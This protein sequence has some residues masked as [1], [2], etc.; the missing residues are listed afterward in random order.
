MYVGILRDLKLAL[1]SSVKNPGMFADFPSSIDSIYDSLHKPNENYVVVV[2]EILHFC[3]TFC[4]VTRMV[5][6]HLPEGEY[7]QLHDN[8][9]R[10]TNQYPRPTLLVKES[11]LSLRDC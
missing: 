8:M 7:D 4:I 3:S 11:L 9:L 6:D 5:E 2:H 10:E 1:P